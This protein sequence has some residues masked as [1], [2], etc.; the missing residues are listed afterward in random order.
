MCV[1]CLNSLMCVENA[2]SDYDELKW[3]ISWILDSISFFLACLYQH[4]MRTLPFLNCAIFISLYMN[5]STKFCPCFA[6]LSV[7]Y[8]HHGVIWTS[9][10]LK[11]VPTRLFVQQLVHTNSTGNQKGTHCWSFEPLCRPRG[12]PAQMGSSV[13]SIS[14]AWRHYEKRNEYC[15]RKENNDPIFGKMKEYQWRFAVSTWTSNYSDFTW[16]SWRHK[17]SG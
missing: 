17:S 15:F 8:G 16:A 11:S 4:T 5:L 1:R 2:A 3:S 13:E 9:W 14:K 12:F 7:L 6:T 10:R